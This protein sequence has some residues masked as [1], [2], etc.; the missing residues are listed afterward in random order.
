MGLGPTD[1]EGGCDAVE[2]VQGLQVSVDGNKLNTRNSC[3]DHPHYGISASP[4]NSDDLDNTW[5]DGTA[6]IVRR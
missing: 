3:L 2:P 1:V 5:G 6:R 4:S